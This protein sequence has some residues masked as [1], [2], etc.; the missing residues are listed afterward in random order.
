MSNDIARLTKVRHELLRLH[1]ALLDGQVA[2]HERA[3]GKIASS[4]KL[5]ELVIS[6]ASFD[7][8]HRL[9]ELIVQIDQ[10][11]EDKKSPLTDAGAREVLERI[12]ALLTPAEAGDAFGR[13]YFEALRD[14]ANVEAVSRGVRGLMNE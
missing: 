4:G 2:R 8:L 12:K 13:S 9:S 11:M 14:D 3:H 5:L 10:A 7:W 6:D 1:K